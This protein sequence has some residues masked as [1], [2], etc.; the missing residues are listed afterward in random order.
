MNGALLTCAFL[1]WRGMHSYAQNYSQKL[2]R[3]R[4]LGRLWPKLENNNV[5]DFL[6][7]RELGSFKIHPLLSNASINTRWHDFM[8]IRCYVATEVTLHANSRR[9]AESSVFYGFDPRLCNSD[10]PAFR[11]G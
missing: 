3:K 11:V 9:I 4:S 5:T 6:S 1:A 7:Q 2:V 8:G 10:P